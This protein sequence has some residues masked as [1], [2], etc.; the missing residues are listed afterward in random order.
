MKTNRNLECTHLICVKGGGWVKMNP[1]SGEKNGRD[2]WNVDNR[3]MTVRRKDGETRDVGA[4]LLLVLFTCVRFSISL[5]K[6]YL[7]ICM[8]AA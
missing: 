1:L 6:N 5:D 7:S 3:L 8:L 2:S 4:V